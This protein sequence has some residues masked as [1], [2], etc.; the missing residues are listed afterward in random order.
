MARPRS[1]PDADIFA[2][3]RKMLAE[4]GPRHLSFASVAARTGLAGSSLVQRYLSRDAMVQAALLEGWDRLDSATRRAAAATPGSAKGAVA[5][6]K[7]IAPSDPALPPSDLRLL[8]SDLTD[9]ALRD[10]AA[11]WRQTLLAALQTKLGDRGPASAEML[12]A[13]WHGRLLWS[14]N[15]ATSTFRLRDAARLLL[16]R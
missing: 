8:M 12:F 13:L 1:I 7:A 4:T 5:L 6:L 15:G 2:V 3:I 9:P 11:H 14:A 10:R 16:A